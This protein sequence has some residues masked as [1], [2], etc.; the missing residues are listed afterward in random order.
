ML[1]EKPFVAATATAFRYLA[2][3]E[4]DHNPHT[5]FAQPSAASRCKLHSMFNL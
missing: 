1:P 3:E 5:S 4:M 2:A